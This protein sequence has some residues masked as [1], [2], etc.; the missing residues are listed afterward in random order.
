MKI[1]VVEDKEMH[2][3][4]ARDSLA[5]HD[6][7]IVDSFDAAMGLMA[8]KIDDENVTRLM[9]EAGFPAT[10]DRNG[11]DE[12]WKAFWKAHR[13]A[14]A[15][16]VVP[17]PFDVVLTDMMMPM[18]RQTLAS[19]AY[20]PAEQVPYGFII[21]LKAAKVGAKF[22]AMVTDTNH[23]KGAMSAAIDHLGT[24]YYREGFKPN[25]GVNGAKVMFVHTPFYRE[26]LGQKDCE[27]CYGSGKCQYCHGS[28]QRHDEYV[29]GEC[30]GCHEDVGKCRTCKGTGKQDDVRQD[31]KDWGQVLADLTAE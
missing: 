7:T 16:S 2:R 9:T 22:V 1:L 24:S 18:S 29:D 25:F 8:K 5:G 15:K 19:E 12:E 26:V 21:A 11:G 23:H 27:Y 17:F 14:E 28:G 4:S 20:H 3:Q 6:V 10:P 13:E 30:N 31:R